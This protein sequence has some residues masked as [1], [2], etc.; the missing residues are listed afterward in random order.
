MW[1]DL[2][3]LAVIGVAAWYGYTHFE[4]RI[5]QALGFAPS[6]PSASVRILPEQFA[7]DGRIYCSQMTS[8][9]EAKYFLRNCPRTKMDGN[10]DGIPCEKQWCK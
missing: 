4:D 3:V 6:T 2:I 5:R 10:G 9:D 8:C 1:K 7:C